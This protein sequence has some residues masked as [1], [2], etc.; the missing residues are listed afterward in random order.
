MPFARFMGTTTGRAVRV[1]AGVVLIVVGLAAGGTAGWIVAAVGLV[2]LTA[3]LAN[4]CLFAPLFHTPFR[5]P[6]DAA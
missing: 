5:G 6:T 3:G 2:P 1:L 4:L